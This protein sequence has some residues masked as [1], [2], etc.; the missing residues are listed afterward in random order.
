ME[1]GP[2]LVLPV[3]ALRRGGAIEPGMHVLAR[4]ERQQ[5]L[6]RHYHSLATARVS[7]AARP[8]FLRSEHPEA[9]QFDPVTTR[10]PSR[11]RVK[12][13]VNNGLSVPPVQVR[14]LRRELCNQFRLDHSSSRPEPFIGSTAAVS[15]Q[16]AIYP[17]ARRLMLLP[18][19]PRGHVV[20]RF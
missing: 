14:V 17:R 16:H 18:I 13:G 5:G 10:E 1:P 11:D 4:L 7:R 19:R 8:P 6:L 12:Y 15:R 9:A 20:I 2:V 3:R